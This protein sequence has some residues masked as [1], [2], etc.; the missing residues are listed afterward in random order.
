[1]A[2]NDKTN[3]K[4]VQQKYLELQLLDEQIKQLQQQFLQMNQQLINL[5]TLIDNLNE[6]KKVKIKSNIL[7]PLGSGVLIEASLNDN[8]NVLVHIGG[9]GVV[10][11]TVE[12]TQETITKQIGE[13][14]KFIE[15]LDAQIQR[16]AYEGELIQ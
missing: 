15:Q 11:K 9:D 1:M 7:V 3:T 12:E 6:L 16:M 5:K 8:K 14:T 13:L 4:E 10:Q 2:Q